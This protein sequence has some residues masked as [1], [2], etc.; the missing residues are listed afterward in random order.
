[1][2]NAL[3]IVSK[4]H[5]FNFFVKSLKANEILFIDEE[6]VIFYELDPT[7]ISNDKRSP[8]HQSKKWSKFFEKYLDHLQPFFHTFYINNL[9]NHTNSNKMRISS[10][11]LYYINKYNL[12]YRKKRNFFKRFYYHNILTF[13]FLKKKMFATL[14]YKS[15][16]KSYVTPGILTKKLG[17][18]SKKSKKSTK[19]LNMVVKTILK[20]YWSNENYY[21]L[22]IQIKGTSL[23]YNKLMEFLKSLLL[24]YTDA[25]FIYTPV[26][27]N[28][29]KKFKKVRSLKKNFRKKYFKI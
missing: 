2:E 12:K 4:K 3:A 5:R 10:T 14:T 8:I 25:Y 24:S 1:M 28:N 15:L 6:Y 27:S 18:E 17:I 9:L 7:N 11:I 29:N 16:L 20:T 22:I 21:K 13:N 26:I 19:L 23:N